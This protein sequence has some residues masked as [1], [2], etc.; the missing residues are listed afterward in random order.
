MVEIGEG[1]TG[2]SLGDRVTTNNIHTSSCGECY[3]CRRRMYD[4]CLGGK[5]NANVAEIS[6]SGYGSRRGAMAEYFRRPANALLNFR[7][8]YNLKRPLWSNQLTSVSAPL[9]HQG[10][11]RVIGSGR[12]TGRMETAR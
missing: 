7:I 5:G 4:M 2:W 11:S 12:R 6:K 1:V 8:A 10:S 9:K 3:Y